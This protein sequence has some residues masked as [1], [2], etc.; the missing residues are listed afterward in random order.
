MNLSFTISGEQTI[1]QAIYTFEFQEIISASC[2]SKF[3][4]SD[5]WGGVGSENYEESKPASKWD[6]RSVV[7]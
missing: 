7:A 3:A 6:N 5:H 1:I 2:P 4:S